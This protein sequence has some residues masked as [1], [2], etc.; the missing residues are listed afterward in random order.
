[1]SELQIALALIGVLAVIGIVIYNRLQERKFRRQAEAGFSPPGEDVLLDAEPMRQLLSRVEPDFEEPQLNDP[2]PRGFHGRGNQEPHFGDTEI[3]LE[4]ALSEDTYPNQTVAEGTDEVSAIPSGT[5][6]AEVVAYD[7][8]IEFRVVLKNLDGMAAGKFGDLISRSASFGKSVRWLGLPLGSPTW[9][10]LSFQNEKS[11]LE[12]Q[13][14][15][16]LADREG[17]AGKDKLSALC[18]LVQEFAQAQGWQMR[19]DDLAEAAVRAQSLDKFCADV[20]VQIGLNIVARGTA[21]LPIARI[22]HEAESVGMRLGASGA[23]QLLDS[24]GEVLFMLGNREPRP[25]S[26]DNAH[27]PETKGV[28]LLFD[29]PRVPDG[30]KNFDSM[31]KLGRKLAHDA[32]GL[33]VDDNLRPL[34][35]IGIEK[36]RAQLAQIY[37]KMEARGVPAGSRVALRLFS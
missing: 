14:V 36:I 33:L 2:I 21:I 28:T 8:S 29:V 1:M 4:A 11:Y 18:D 24:R 20:D 23:Y 37:N 5:G 34:T 9:E 17:A 10:D 16:Q 26:R 25:F 30:L 13:A 22:R 32:G 31:V 27:E 6:T 12:V 35:D 19:C 15:M 3:L 7:D